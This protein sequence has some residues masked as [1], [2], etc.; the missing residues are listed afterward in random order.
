[1]NYLDAIRRDDVTETVMVVAQ[2]LREVMKQDKQD[3]KW[4]SVEAV[5]RFGQLGVAEEWRQK[6]ELKR[7]RQGLNNYPLLPYKQI[8]ASLTFSDGF[9]CCSLKVSYNE[10]LVL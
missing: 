1:M 8:L 6:F 5:N 7:R 10:K 9:V 2:E 3:S 4:T